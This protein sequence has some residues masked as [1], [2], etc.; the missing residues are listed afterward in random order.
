MILIQYFVYNFCGS[1]TFAFP[2]MSF[3]QGNYIQQ[4]KVECHE[5]FLTIFYFI[6]PT[7]INRLKWFLLNIRS[8]YQQKYF[9][10]VKCLIVLQHILRYQQNKWHWSLVVSDLL[11]L[12]KSCSIIKTL[13]LR[14]LRTWAQA[15]KLHTNYNFNSVNVYTLCTILLGTRYFVEGPLT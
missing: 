11:F 15:C 8:L 13:R 14:R 6:N 10:L 4:L 5:I 12:N 7:L 2:S 3:L 1:L 9:M